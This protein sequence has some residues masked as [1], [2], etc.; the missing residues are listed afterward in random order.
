MDMTTIRVARR[1]RYAAVDRRT[2][3]DGRLSFR[4]RGVLVWLLDKPDGFTI[5]RDALASAGPEG[6][7]VVRQV[8]AELR[9]CG[10]LVRS[11]TRLPSGR[12]TTESVLYEVPP[13]VENQP[14]VPV[15]GYR[16]TVTDQRLPNQSIPKTDP[17]T[18]QPPTPSDEG[19]TRINPRANGT[20]PRAI[21]T[22]PRAQGDAKQRYVSACQLGRSWVGAFDSVED[23]REAFTA[24]LGGDEDQAQLA[25]DSW[26]EAEAE[27]AA[28]EK[29]A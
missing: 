12:F 5:S 28:K 15:D 9:T 18:V 25:F 22:N 8:L 27:L 11:Q 20:N 26:R 19:E 2:I 10:Y 4:A 16:P 29:P 23:A 14:P 24:A 1:A 6:H 7:H 3:N 13:V 21:G 17:K